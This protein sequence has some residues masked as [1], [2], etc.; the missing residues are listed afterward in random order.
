M[1][2]RGRSRSVILCVDDQGIGVEL[3]KRVLEKLGF[4][5]L[6]ATSA[7][8]ALEVFRA[9]QIDLVLAEHI[10]PMVVGGPT[11]LATMRML[12]PEVPVAILSADAS[13]SPEEISC[14]DVFITKLVSVNE[15][16]DIIERLLLKGPITA[17]PNVALLSFAV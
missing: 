17:A 12:K 13:A 1:D 9:N 15:L 4:R 3:R 10:E 2:A 11:L 14:A 5:V 16:V 8:Q 7:H 6:L